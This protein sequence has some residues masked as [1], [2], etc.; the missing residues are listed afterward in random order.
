MKKKFSLKNFRETEAEC[1][2]NEK[3]K[4]EEENVNDEELLKENEDFLVKDSKEEIKY[5]KNEMMIYNEIEAK[6]DEEIIQK[7]LLNKKK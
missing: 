2:D 4:S 6:K 5:K 7:I 1:S 3:N